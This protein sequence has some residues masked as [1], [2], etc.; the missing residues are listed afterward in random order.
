MDGSIN[1]SELATLSLLGGGYGYGNIGVGRGAYPGETGSY[2]SYGAGSN[3]YVADKIDASNDRQTLEELRIQNATS[4]SEIKCGNA[5]ANAAIRS[6]NTNR[7]VD[8]LNSNF[9]RLDDKNE[10]R[11]NALEAENRKTQDIIMNNEITRLRDDK[12]VLLTQNQTLQFENSQIKQTCELKC[13]P[14]CNDKLM[15][16]ELASIKATLMHLVHKVG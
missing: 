14:T 13:T 2:G 16:A 10:A 9:A 6:A 3:L 15:D 4:I 8:N 11:F 1:P 7:I 5:E 12:N